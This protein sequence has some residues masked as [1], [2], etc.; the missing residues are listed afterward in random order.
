M[1]Y[2]ETL[3]YLY[4]ALPMF[5][6]TGAKAIKPDLRNTELL[7]E[8]LNHPEKKI[9]TIHIAGTN[10]KGSVS[11]M[12]AAIFQQNGYQTGLYTSPH[13]KD[14][15]ERIRMNGKMIPKKDVINF[16]KKT[17]SFAEEIHPSFFELT[18]GMALDFFAEKKV[19]IAI[20]ETGLGGRL[21]STNVIRPELSIITNI[22]WDHMDV[23]GDTLEKIA[24]EKAGIIKPKVPVVIGETR[25]ETQKIF[26]KK[27]KSTQSEIS[28][29]D[30]HYQVLESYT[31][32]GKLILK[33]R[34]NVDPKIVSYTLDLQGTYQ[35]KNILTVLESVAL[36]KKRFRLKQQ[37]IELALSATTRLTGLQG[38]WQVISPK[39]LVV[40]DVAHNQDGIKEITNQ[41]GHVPY[42]QLYLVT[43]MVKDKVPDAVLSL[44]P[45]KATYFFCNAQIPRAMPAAELKKK[46]YAFGLKGKSYATVQEA[47]DAACR[48][49]NDDDFILICGSV[50]VAGEVDIRHTR[51]LLKELPQSNCK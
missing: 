35:E 23:L 41:L 14:F 8:F 34:G 4:R 7:C 39:P 43:G 2:Q 45:K 26:T 29:A 19:D 13:L 25:K 11:N 6:R 27:A 3:N 49:A 20:I 31:D 24:F 22:G 5:S 47:V 21:D 50:F 1:N 33:I 36:L 12:L 10:G 48:Q 46:A 42:K 17:K 30:Q 16:V 32:K 40:I 44:L 37:A 18:F 9:K 28:F 51:A 38:R 15:R